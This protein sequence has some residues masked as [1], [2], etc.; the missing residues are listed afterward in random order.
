MPRLKG[1]RFRSL[2]VNGE[3]QTP[4]VIVPPERVDTNWRLADG[5]RLAPDDLQEV[6]AGLP[7]HLVIGAGSYG[8]M[9]PDPAVNHRRRTA[10]PLHLGWQPVWSS[11]HHSV[12]RTPAPGRPITTHRRRWPYATMSEALAGS[13]MAPR[14]TRSA[15]RPRNE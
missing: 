2:A 8:P 11:S 7:E 6:R 4:D 3:V 12:V 13:P 14:S 10:A 5:H 9:H 15:L 1:Y